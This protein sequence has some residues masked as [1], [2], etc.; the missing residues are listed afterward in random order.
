MFNKV[1]WGKIIK[2]FAQFPLPKGIKQRDIDIPEKIPLKRS[3]SIIG[4][5]RSGKTYEMFLLIKNLL[6]KGIEINQMQYINFESFE[7]VGIKLC[8]MED[9]L[10]VYYSIYPENYQKDLW[11]FL[12]EIQT[13]P[14]WEKWVRS[15][16]DKDIHV[17]LSGSSSKLLSKEIATQ[18]RGRNLTYEIFP[19]NFREYLVFHS[20][21]V[22]S[23]LSTKKEAQIKKYVEKYLNWGGYPEISLYEP[24]KEKIL[25]EILNVTIQKDVIERYHIRNEKILRLLVKALINSKQFS[26]RK[27]HNFLKSSGQSVS[28]NTLYSYLKYLTDSMTVYTLH[29]YSPTFK[30]EERSRPKI[31]FIDNGLLKISGINDKGRLL[32]NCVFTELLR[33]YKLDQIR[34]F[35]VDR[36]EVD[37]VI[38]Q[39]K[40]IYQLIQ[41]SYDLSDFQTR[42]R[43]Y[44]AL[45]QA[46]KVLENNNLLLIT[47][48]EEGEEVFKDKKISIIPLWKWLLRFRSN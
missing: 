39:G 1:P 42:E 5:R 12:D 32:E 31:Y 34:Y 28:K 23:Y 9:F 14:E 24:A 3:I 47:W 35:L 17:Y 40:K 27:F 10:S 18:M 43:E 36:R 44:K 37:F 22:E 48:N 2:D 6:N 11:L 33:R 19:L 8:D 4:P 13:L 41:V 45:I 29:K 20:I 16:I 46:S 26:V 21:Q 30:E 7:L 38:L 15:L 25:N